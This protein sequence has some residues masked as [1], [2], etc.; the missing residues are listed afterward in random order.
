VYHILADVF[1]LLRRYDAAHVSVSSLGMPMN[2]AVTS[3]IVYIRFHGLQ[4]GAAHDYTRA[5][6]KPW[7]QHIREQ[8]NTG[9]HVYAYFNNDANVRAP[10]NAKLLIELTK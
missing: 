2:L 8:S 3:D 7:A 9:K 10:A 1:D 5:E 6:L 4:G